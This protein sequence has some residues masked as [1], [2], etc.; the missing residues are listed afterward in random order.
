MAINR[1]TPIDF[2]NL[3]MQ[4][5]YDL[6]KYGA[7]GDFGP[8]TSDAI[9]EW[10]NDGVDLVEAATAPEPGPPSGGGIVPEDWMPDCAMLRVIAHW[11]AGAYTVSSTDKQHYHII[12]DGD[13]KLFRGDN[14][15]ADN[16]STAD[17]DYAAHTKNCNT[18]SIGISVA[19]MAGA[20]ESPFN[21]G[22]YPITQLQWETLAQV[23]AELCR[24]YDI[25]VTPYSVLQHG[26]V[27][28]NLGIAQDGKWD[29]C[30]L[31]WEPSWDTEQVGNDF[32]SRVTK[33]L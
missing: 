30:K 29:I 18:Q 22:R 25:A 4:A 28:D 14:S 10:F 8:E 9:E 12:V 7:D 15:I 24:K 19:C 21:A 1:L 17:D 11:T 33:L 23:A 3:L 31:P 16:V 32:R 2:Q 20:I 26:E 13:G 27:E 6:P 5:D